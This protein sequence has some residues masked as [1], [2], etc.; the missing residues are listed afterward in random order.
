MTRVLAAFAAWLLVPALAVAQTTP[1]SGGVP[2]G[3]P[4]DTPLA[5]TLADAIHRGLSQ[6]L[7]VILQEQQLHESGS[8]R[9]AALSDLVPHLSADVRQT[10]Q[11]VNLAAFG[12]RGFDGIEIPTLIG[13]FDVFDARLALSTPVIDIA[14]LQHLR[15]ANAAEDAARADYRQTRETVVLAV[16]NLY[17]MALADQARLD[18]AN[19]RVDTA[20]SLA[21]LA[22]DQHASGLV[23]RIDVVRQQVELQSAKSDQLTAST[24]LA[25]RKLQ[26]ARAIGLPAGQ[27][28]T[29]ATQSAFIAT[30]VPTLDAALQEALAHRPDL[31]GRARPRGRRAGSPARG[32]CRVAAE[33]ARRCGLRCHRQQPAIGRAHLHGGC[34]RCTCHLF[35]R[36]DAGGRPADRRGA[37]RSARLNSPMPRTASSTDLQTALLTLQSAQA[38]VEVAESAQSLARD[39]LTQAQDR[40]RAGVANTL[41]LVEA[42][43][44]VARATEQYIGSVYTHTIAKAGLARAMGDVEARFLSLVGGQQ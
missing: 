40:F 27:T 11:V 8:A 33:P 43:E 2:T 21:Q 32:R 22:A 16:G 17:L 37:P 31:G 23:P 25:T 41:E 6:N 18:A 14:A 20:N 39:E 28:F 30:P 9:L 29:L 4:S 7:A 42:Q 13:P 34:L 26:L 35:G 3:T 1:L 5:L 44:A 38:G 36:Q 10:R 19:A 12:F 15:S 24:T